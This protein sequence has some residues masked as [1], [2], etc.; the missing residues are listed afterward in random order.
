MLGLICCPV[1]LGS[2]VVSALAAALAD[3]PRSSSKPIAVGWLCLPYNA[4][5][6]APRFSVERNLGCHGGDQYASVR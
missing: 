1:S 4:A 2:A 6:P 5:G 3:A